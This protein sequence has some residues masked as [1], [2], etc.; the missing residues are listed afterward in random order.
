MREASR[1][2]AH[3]DLVLLGGVEHKRSGTERRHRYADLRLL[4]MT[5]NGHA[6]ED[7]DDQTGER[8]GRHLIHAS[9]TPASVGTFTSE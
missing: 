4:C 5:G 7:A 8:A 6:D 9:L 1:H 2:D 3:A